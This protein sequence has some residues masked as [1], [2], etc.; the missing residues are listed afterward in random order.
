MSSRLREKPGDRSP[1]HRPS[2]TAFLGSIFLRILSLTALAALI[3][4]P[5]VAQVAILQIQVAAGEGV[6]HAAGSRDA[7]GI[8]VVVTDETGRPVEGAAVAFH[9]PDQGPSGAFV[10]GL[11]TEVAVTDERGRASVHAIEYNR[12]PGR[13]EIRIVA[14]K[15][16]ARAGTVTF[17]Y[18]DGP[19]PGSGETVAAE[20]GRHHRKLW[21]AV[22]V[23]AGVGAA[24]G[25]LGLTRSSSSQ[26][27]S[28]PATISIGTP[29]VTVGKP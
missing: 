6:V 11:R 23:V 18:I 14:S 13:M 21:I 17:Q 3:C 16:Q 22:A 20:P 10:N 5:A 2:T 15:E 26:S 25:V 24:G 19:T 8:A 27:T 29:S 12:L 4:R 28:A 1:A 7:H 9:L